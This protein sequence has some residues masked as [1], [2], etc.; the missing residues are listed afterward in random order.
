MS[1]GE[2]DNLVAIGQL[3]VEPGARADP[4][5]GRGCLAKG[6]AIA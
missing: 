1:N 5:A 6:S 3:K 2:L 4:A